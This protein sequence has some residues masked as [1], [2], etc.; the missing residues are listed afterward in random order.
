MG[1][2]TWQSLPTT[3]KPLPGRRNIVV[4]RQ[5]EFLAPGAQTS[6]SLAEA[7]EL[8]ASNS[9]DDFF[10]IGGASLYELALPLTKRI[11]LTEIDLKVKGDACFPALPNN[12]WQESARRQQISANGIRYAFVTLTR[13]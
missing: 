13:R 5:A 11:Y 12:V 1:R 3:Y 2:K 9:D 8:A 4:S 7:I 6:T 10:V